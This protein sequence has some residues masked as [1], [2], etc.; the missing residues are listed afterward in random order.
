MDRVLANPD[1]SAA[2][3]VIRSAVRLVAA[4]ALTVFPNNVATRPTVEDSRDAH[5]DT[6]RHAVS[7]IEANASHDVTLADIAA[8]AHVT[9]RAIQLAFR[10]HLDV[11]P[12]AYLRRVR[13]DLARSDLRGAD[14]GQG[15]TVTTIAYRWGFPS[16]SIFAKQYR[17]TYGE[18]PSVTLRGR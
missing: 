17:T 16:A 3:L 1:A 2:P 4:T 5:P 6:V 15:V 10:R 12:M 13:L 14:P 7:Y 8:A 18:L 9:N 11:T